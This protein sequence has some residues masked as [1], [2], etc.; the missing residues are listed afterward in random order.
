MAPESEG[1]EPIRPEPQQSEEGQ[2]ASLHERL[3]QALGGRPPVS[4]QTSLSGA[5]MDRLRTSG[6]AIR[7]VAP[8]NM[9]P[10]RC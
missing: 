6:A 5:L 7:S 10:V 4:Q 1:R 2:D 9:N 3:L 8:E